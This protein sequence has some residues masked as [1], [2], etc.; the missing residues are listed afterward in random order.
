MTRTTPCAARRRPNGSRDPVGDADFEAFGERVPFVGEAQEAAIVRG[1][2]RVLH[3]ER[4]VVFINGA[5]D[6]FGLAFCAGVEAADDALQVGELF[7][8]EGR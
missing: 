3:A 8:H 1:G 2:D 6:F 7:N 4:F 5:P